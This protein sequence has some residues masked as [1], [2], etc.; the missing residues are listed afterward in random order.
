M[1]AT[2][3]PLLDTALD[4]ALDDA[5]ARIAELSS[6]L[7]AVSDLHAPRRTLL[8]ATSCRAC[9]RSW[10]CPTVHATR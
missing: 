2:A 3:D 7:H 10:P 6:R 5:L 1:S 9:R 4:T 8:G